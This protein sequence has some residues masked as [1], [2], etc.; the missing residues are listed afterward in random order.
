MR[1]MV[2]GA[3]GFVA[4]SLLRQAGDGV[5]VHAVSRGD[6]I[7]QRPGMVW[8]GTD[9]CDSA[10]L[11]R[12]VEM[13][14]PDAI[15]HTAAIADIDYCEAHRDEAEQ[16]NAG[17]PR[18]LAEVCADAGIR[19]VHVSTDTVFDGEKGL[20]AEGDPPGPLNFYAETKVWAEE[21]VSAM[22]TNWVV[23][24][25]S[26][27]MGLPV[28]GRG[29]SFLSRMMDKFKAGENVGVPDKEIRSAIDVI[30][31][32]RALLELATND[33]V[34]YL[35]LAGNDVENRYE[36]VC[37]LAQKLGYS[38]E[39]V[40][41]NDPS[42]I[43]GRAPRPRDVSLDNAKARALLENPMCGLLEGLDRV[44][45]VKKETAP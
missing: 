8:H 29:N 17:V 21:A 13:V 44:L 16:V 39:L 28:L 27:V 45:A 2:T 19:L 5:E 34:G 23:A 37:R 30:T 3:R 10:A 42:A 26:L 1:L 6:A 4:G 14:Q 36:M 15:V 7:Y 43:S 12:L 18:V 40:Y 38:R 9:L 33:Y 22:P 41:A 11:R 24:R 32:G 25:T 20:Y 31:L 35:H